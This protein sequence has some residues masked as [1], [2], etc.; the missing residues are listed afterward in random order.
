MASTIPSPTHRSADGNGLV[1]MAWD[2]I[3][4]I[5]G[6]L[7][8]YT[9][10]D[11]NQ[12]EVVECHS[13]SSIFRGYSIFMKGKDP[14]DA[15]FITSRICGICGD[16]HATC[17]CYAQNMAYGVKPPHLGEWIVNLREAAEDMF[18]HNIFEESLVGVDYCERMVAET[19][20]GVLALAEQAEAPH[21]RDHGYRR[22]ADIMRAQPVHRRVLPR[23]AAGLA[24]DPR[25][26]LP[27]GG[28]A[29]APL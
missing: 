27:H 14:R 18:D 28:A 26:V 20:P 16:N 9:K 23:G 15:H 21:A 3:T 29:R 19:N 13:T 25:D 22:I 24:G 8:I 17:S 7:G 6:S 5:V 11:F 12:R 2:P 1:E 4:R 10:I